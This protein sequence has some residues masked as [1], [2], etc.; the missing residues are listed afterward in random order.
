VIEK[1]PYLKEAS[2][3]G[4]INDPECGGLDVAALHQG[5]LRGAKKA[6]ATV[7]VNAGLERA[8]RENGRWRVKIRHGEIYT[9]TIINTAGAW[10]DDVAERCGIAPLGIT[11]LQRTI[12][13]VG[14][15]E[16]L[17]FNPKSPVVIDVDERFY[18]KVEG[19]GYLLSPADETPVAASDAQPD[20]EDV[21]YAVHYFEEATGASIR[22]IESKW[23]GLRSFAKDR[24]PVIGYDPNSE[25]FFWN[26]GQGGYGIQTSPAWSRVAANLI[27]GDDIPADL[28][29]LGAKAEDYSPDR[30]T[31]G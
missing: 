24:A 9:K 22:N 25:G 11:P 10:A 21:A 1:A 3:V 7:M 20:M 17:E 6:G 15:P 19:H 18:F 26:V 13:S 14:H 29:D 30:F 5:Y 23:A 28:Q 4:G 8:V 27:L 12:V 31:V 2:I 16:G